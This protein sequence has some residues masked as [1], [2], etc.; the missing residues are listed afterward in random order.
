MV[1]QKHAFNN[2][3]NNT[4]MKRQEKTLGLLKTK[5][6]KIKFI[7]KHYHMGIMIQCMNLDLY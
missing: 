1:K 6:A 3:E 4:T 5:N 7:M 2:M